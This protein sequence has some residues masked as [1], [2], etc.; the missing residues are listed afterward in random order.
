ME[1]GLFKPFLRH[2]KYMYLPV[3]E[4]KGPL[5]T[6]P[7]Q[8]KYIHAYL[9]WTGK[10]LFQPFLRYSKYITYLFW[11]ASSNH[12]WDIVNTCTYLFWK[13]KASSNHSW[14]IV[15]TCTY[16]FWMERASSNHSWDIVNTCTYLFWR[17]KDLFQPFLGHSKYMYLPVLGGKGPLPTIPGT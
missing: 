1:K 2:S 7:G 8:S 5:P 9:F 12:S 17:G 6:I 11:V 4:G 15:N 13:G 10:G 3:L 16:L 14:D